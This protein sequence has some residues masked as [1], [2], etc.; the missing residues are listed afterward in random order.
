MCGCGCLC[1]FP[2][3]IAN[4]D[5]QI[6]LNDLI[7]GNLSYLFVFKEIPSN[8]ESLQFFYEVISKIIWEEDLSCR[9]HACFSFQMFCRV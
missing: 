1:G 4:S 5:V 6:C 9:V 2:V 8:Q 7:F 3:S